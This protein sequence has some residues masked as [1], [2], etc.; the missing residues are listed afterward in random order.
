MQPGA[1]TGADMAENVGRRKR[2]HGE[3]DETNHNPT[4]TPCGHIQH[5]YEHGEEHE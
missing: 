5:G 2:A 4:G 3:R 1:N